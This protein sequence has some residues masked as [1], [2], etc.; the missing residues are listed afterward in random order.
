MT[1]LSH[2]S[3]LSTHVW[4]RDKDTQGVSFLLIRFTAPRAANEDVIRN[5]VITK[6]GLGDTGVSGSNEVNEGR[7]LVI[8]LWECHLWPGH[9]SIT[10]LTVA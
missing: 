2:E 9:R 10:T 8:I 6:K 7:Y 4:P 1:H 3:G 5:E